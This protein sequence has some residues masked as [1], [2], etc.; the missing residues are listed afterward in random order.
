MRKAR[1]SSCEL[2]FSDNYPRSENNK[3]ICTY[4][5]RAGILGMVSR[6][7]G[8]L[9]TFP[10]TPEHFLKEGNFCKKCLVDIDERVEKIIQ[11]QCEALGIVE[12]SDIKRVMVNCSKCGQSIERAEYRK[13]PFECFDC[14]KKRHRL[15]ARSYK[16][17]GEHEG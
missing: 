3:R 14:K 6:C 4:C 7:Y 15:L 11:E 1:C 17:C 13:P 5:E 10:N 8:C 16:A 9:K 12:S 2:Y